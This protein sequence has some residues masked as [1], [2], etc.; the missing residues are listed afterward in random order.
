MLLANR[1]WDDAR[2]LSVRGDIRDRTLGGE[3]P[4]EEVGARVAIHVTTDR[5]PEKVENRR[6]HVDDR[7]A[8]LAARGDGGAVSQQKAV[9]GI[10]V[11]GGGGTSSAGGYW[12]G[13]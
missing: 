6:C 13:S 11:K 9:G 2:S 1:R 7:A 12:W 5:D 10:L 8:L 3:D 4:R